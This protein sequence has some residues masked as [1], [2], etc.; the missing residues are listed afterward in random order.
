M[1][2]KNNFKNEGYWLLN[3]AWKNIL[4]HI[5]KKNIL[6]VNLKIKYLKTL[7]IIE[8]KNLFGTGHGEVHVA[9]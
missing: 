3:E 4:F 8:W 9:N 1:L 2:I 7:I 6:L 5:L